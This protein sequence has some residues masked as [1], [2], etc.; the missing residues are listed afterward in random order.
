MGTSRVPSHKVGDAD[1]RVLADWQEE[2]ATYSSSS[3]EPLGRETSSSS[4]SCFLLRLDIVMLKS[5]GSQLTK[6]SRSGGIF[7]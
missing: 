6:K 5:G 7:W 1:G 2:S 3:S 4:S